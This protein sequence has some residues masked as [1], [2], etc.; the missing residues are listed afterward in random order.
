MKKR[1]KD[2]EN[3]F[4]TRFKQLR[5]E[6][7][8]SQ[9]ELAK[10]LTLTPQNIS[11]FE[12]G[13]EPNYKILIQIADFFQVTV[14][15][16]LGSSD[17]KT[18]KEENLYASS[19]SLYDEVRGLEEKNKQKLLQVMHTIYVFL[20]QCSESENIEAMDKTNELFKMLMK[21]KT[22]HNEGK[23]KIFSMVSKEYLMLEVKEVWNTSLEQQRNQNK[24]VLRVLNELIDLLL[25]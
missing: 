1:Q 2:G 24:E 5:E 10:I 12:K 14:D 9:A 18:W 16:L 25:S 21:L 23:E 20:Q 4:H 6:R 7:N 3:L 13:R 17:F 8:M 11:Y 22:K 15:Y 19:L